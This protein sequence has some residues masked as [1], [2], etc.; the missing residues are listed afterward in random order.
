MI[1]NQGSAPKLLAAG[2]AVTIKISD[3][4]AN[5]LFIPDIEEEPVL[6][7][8]DSERSESPV[9]VSPVLDDIP[10]EVLQVCC[11][12]KLGYFDM[13]I[14]TFYG[15]YLLLLPLCARLLNMLFFLGFT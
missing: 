1:F 8:S 7:R 9:T 2:D 6:V 12:C 3:I 13:V 14:A 10:P 5:D 11:V 15:N 4:F